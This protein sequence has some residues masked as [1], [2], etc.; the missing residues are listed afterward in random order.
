MTTTQKANLTRVLTRLVEVAR[1]D[2][3][4]TFLE[5]EGLELLQAMG[6]ATPRHAFVSDVSQVA[7]VDL[8]AFASASVVVKVVAPEIAHKSDVGGVRLCECAHD[9]IAAT[10]YNMETA[11]ERIGNRG[12]LIA[13]RVDYDAGLGGE[14]LVGARSTAEF[15]SVVVFG[16][17]GIYAEYLAQHLRES[18]RTAVMSATSSPLRGIAAVVEDTAVGPLLTRGLRGQRPRVDA[19]TLVEL[20]ERIRSFAAE[21]MPDPIQAFEVNPMVARDG[22]L[23]AL[24][25]LVELAKG[26]AVVSA[27]RP[28]EKIKNLLEPR[29]VAVI[30]VSQRMNPGKIIVSNLIREGFDRTRIY[31]IKPD[32]ETISGCACYPD[33]ASLPERVDLLVL[34]VAAAQVPEILEE[35]IKHEKAESLIVIPGGLEEKAG[36]DDIVARATSALIASRETAWQG[37]VIN[38]GNSL[39]VR[40]RPGNIDTQ[41]IPDHKL[42]VLPFDEAP[43]AFISQSGAFGI[44]RNSKLRRVRPKFM[45]SVGNQMDLTI[46]DYLE[47]LKA[48]EEI[49]TFAVYAEGFKP[50]DGLKFIEAAR[51][52]TVGGR[53]VLLYRAGRTEA[54]AR[55]SASHTASIAGDYAVTRALAENAGVI[56][57]DTLADFDDLLML[58]C[59]LR[60]YAVGRRI[61]AASNAGF[62]SV[63]MADRIGNLEFAEFSDETMAQLNH[64]FAAARL[65]RV[66]DVHNPLDVTP[67][68]ADENYAAALRAVLDDD[69]VDVGLFGCVP[70][71]PAL[72]T[73]AVGYKH[74]E[75]LNRED[76]LAN[77][78]ANLFD[79]H[80]KPFVAVVDGGRVYDPMAAHLLERGV[81]TFR[82]ADRALRAL[83]VYLSARLAHTQSV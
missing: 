19:T 10:V 74:A 68:M 22:G 39:G 18:S 49:E 23:V 37:P 59:S 44:A 1:A 30:G 15:G 26:E 67:I 27:P 80:N 55:A 7:A 58:F 21:F 78:M 16:A 62:E 61:G 71:T 38:G 35:A 81:P 54:G 72:N 52:I 28:T 64:I 6:I 20:L 5:T 48:D 41:F 31:V 43:L 3:R 45:I 8:A 11:L 42:G 13:E 50:L 12:F 2:D 17:G 73:L 69:C 65:D 9:A 46:G 4:S 82:T 56:V 33:I 66:V 76:S 51:D 70:L 83:R 53:N 60:R 40:S 34:S 63:A 57:A 24:D 29:T 75:D 25:V 14:L 36:S 32:A 79:S 77:R 47:Y